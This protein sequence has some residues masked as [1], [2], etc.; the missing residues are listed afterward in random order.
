MENYYVEFNSF[1]EEC[2]EV[3]MIGSKIME[4][5]QIQKNKGNEA[6]KNENFKEAISYYK[7]AVMYI[8]GRQWIETKKDAI[9]LKAIC[10]SNISACCVKLNDFEGGLES[11]QISLNEDPKNLKSLYRKAFCLVELNSQTQ[12]AKNII[13]YLLKINPTS[14]ELVKLLDKINNKI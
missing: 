5:S 12:I 13:Q 11:A 2:D 10:W 1:C 4:Y 7:K 6:F 3:E 9:V 8:A 14:A